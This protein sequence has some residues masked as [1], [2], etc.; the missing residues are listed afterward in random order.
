MFAWPTNLHPLDVHG[1]IMSACM[2]HWREPEEAAKNIV[3]SAYKRGGAEKVL[4]RRSLSHGDVETRGKGSVD[5]QPVSSCATSWEGVKR[6]VLQRQA[7]VCLTELR[8]IPW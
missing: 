6:K 4:L 8:T 5:L 2:R 1:A 7:A 3:R